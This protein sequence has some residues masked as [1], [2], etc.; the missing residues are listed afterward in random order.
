MTRWGGGY[1][2]VARLWWI[3][4][5]CVFRKCS[6]SIKYICCLPT[7]ACDLNT[8][9][10]WPCVICMGVIH[11]LFFN[12]VLTFAHNSFVILLSCCRI[13]MKKKWYIIG[14]Q[15][16]HRMDLLE[17]RAFRRWCTSHIVLVDV[18]GSTGEGG[19]NISNSRVVN[20]QP[21]VKLIGRFM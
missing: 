13:D 1:D 8:L 4:F 3:Q 14:T 5:C 16:D 6:V 17:E 11:T 12:I 10:P 7:E 2:M 18:Q 19:T 9:S 21:V 15:G 20:W